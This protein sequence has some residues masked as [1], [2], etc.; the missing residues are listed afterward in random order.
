MQMEDD[1]CEDD[2]CDEA[3]ERAGGSG[4]PSSSGRHSNGDVLLSAAVNFRERCKYIPLRLTLEQRR[5]LRLLEAALH[6]SEYT[7]KVG[8]G[9]GWAPAALPTCGCVLQGC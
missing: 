2:S 7:D 5:L 9:R 1:H 6:V 8:A 4:E 3:A